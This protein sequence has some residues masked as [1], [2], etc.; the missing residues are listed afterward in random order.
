M[1]HLMIDIEA[2]DDKP[3][4]AITAIA[5]AF[6]NPETGEVGKTFYRRISLDDAMKNGGTV[7]AEAITWCLKQSSETRSNLLYDDCQDIDLAVCDFYDFVNTN[8]N[9]FEVKVWH[10]CPSLRSAILRTA[11]NKFVGECFEYGSEQSVVTVNELAMSLGLNMDSIIPCSGL[12]NAYEQI[13]YNIKLVSY[14][15]MYL[16]KIASVK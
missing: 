1:K 15:W 8:M 3:T 4:A 7:S 2:M 12:R 16:V 14:V 5:A 11:M 6:F 13:I 10:G 9:P